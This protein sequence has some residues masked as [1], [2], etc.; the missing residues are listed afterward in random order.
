MDF[1]R[2]RAKPAGSI[3]LGSPKS[4][5]WVE[6]SLSFI[7]IVFAVCF[8]HCSYI[9]KKSSHRRSS[10]PTCFLL[11]WCI[12]LSSELVFIDSVPQEGFSTQLVKDE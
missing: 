4:D 8:S 2:R 5:V 12:M 1:S 10:H 11:I 3:V 6:S 7:T 9:T